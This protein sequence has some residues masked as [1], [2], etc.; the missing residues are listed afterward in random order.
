MSR[1]KVHVLR[2]VSDEERAELARMAQSNSAPAEWVRRA[3]LLLLV[4]RGAAYLAAARSVGR[5]NGEGVS[6]L[7]ERFNSEGLEALVP[8]HGGGPKRIYGAA[9]RERIVAEVKR[10]PVVARD[11][12]ASWSLSTLQRSLRQ[13]SDGL[14][15]V[16]TY[17]I[18]QALLNAGYS[19]QRD[20]TW[21][22]TGQVVR[23]R[24]S[25]SVVVE[26]ADA[27]AKKKR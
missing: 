21:C 19:C 23:V 4:E 5:R 2:A 1:Q 26:D 7:V 13:A 3:K 12:T 18:R 10:T 22:Q 8:R 16:S 24:K 20:R 25:G 11:G 17:T 6:A 15:A 27:E 9:E 14:P